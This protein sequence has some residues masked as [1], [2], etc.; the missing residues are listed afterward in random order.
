MIKRAFVQPTSEEIKERKKMYREAALLG[1]DLMEYD[2][3]RQSSMERRDRREAVVLLG[4]GRAIPEELRE[5][6]IKRK[7]NKRNIGLGKE[8]NHIGVR[9]YEILN[10][11]AAV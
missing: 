10:K 8:L 2:E 3:S 7:T 4:T 5:R 11:E 9:L 1:I 6:L